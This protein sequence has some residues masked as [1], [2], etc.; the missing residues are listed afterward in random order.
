[1]SVVVRP[2][3]GVRTAAAQDAA[4]AGIPDETLIILQKAFKNKERIL[5][6]LKTDYEKLIKLVS[7][8]QSNQTAL[9]L[10]LEKVRNYE[11]D[12]GTIDKEKTEVLHKAVET[13]KGQ[14]KAII[15]NLP[16]TL[17]LPSDPPISV[18]L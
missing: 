5:T 17:H 6:D 16:Q 2:V 12:I 4:Q 7:D 10:E 15:M 13:L 9:L 11:T 8:I 1:M 3:Y 14:A 18:M